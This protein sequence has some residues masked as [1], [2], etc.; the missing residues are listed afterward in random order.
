MLLWI[1]PTTGLAHCYESDKSQPGRPW[2]ERTL[3][4]HDWLARAFSQEADAAATLADS[5]DWLFREA[6][7][8]M[9]PTVALVA[10]QRRRQ[11]LIQRAPYAGRGF[12]EPGLDPEL[13]ALIGDHL[14]PW[15]RETPGPEVMAQ[16]TTR[17][18]T[19][20]RS[21]NNRRNLLG[22]GFEDVL[23][24]II[25]RAAPTVPTI[26]TR[27]LLHEV[28]GFYPHGGAKPNRPDLALVA[29]NGHRS[30]VTAKW[31]IRADREKQFLSDYRDYARLESDSKPFDHI[32]ITNEFD[33]A[34]LVAACERQHEGRPL[35]THV[36][37]VQPA[38]L[39][40]TYD[41]APRKSQA[42]VIQHI[43]AGR[44]MSLENWLHGLCRVT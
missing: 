43:E 6:S 18:H 42:K 14:A 38:A 30:V 24:A 4:F 35:F 37:H 12:P 2:Y 15:V 31:S 36:V 34:R 41:P 10:E 28:G 11:A 5:I 40:A 32:V 16:L 20:M 19:H 26:L 13:V 27:P 25:R 7:S 1:D 33:P 44:L 23:A 29:S 9:L 17:I 39:V 21:E 3:R 22:E 8:E